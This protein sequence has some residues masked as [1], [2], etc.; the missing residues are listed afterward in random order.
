[1][2]TTATPHGTDTIAT[3]II[4]HTIVPTL[5]ETTGLTLTVAGSRKNATKGN[6]TIGDSLT[7]DGKAGEIMTG[8][9]ITAGTG[10]KAS[11]LS[12]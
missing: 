7:G 1:M 8:I 12:K 2:L 3:V 10:K 6:V 5:K 4:M 9:G 11:I